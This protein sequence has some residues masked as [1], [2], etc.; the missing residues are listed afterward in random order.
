[1]T[2]AR[3]PF[4]AAS[5][6]AATALLG[7][8]DG[9]F[10]QESDG[11]SGRARVVVAPLSPGAG[12]D[13]D[14]SEDVAE[15]IREGLETFALLTAVD[16]DQIDDMLDR[17]DLDWERMD[18]VQWRQ[19][20][21]Q[22]DGQL[23]V[24]GTARRE[25]GG[26]TVD[27]TFVDAG[28]G[29]EMDVAPFTVPGDGRRSREDAARR[30]L[31]ALEEQVQFLSS[32][33]NCSEYL[34]ADQYEDALRNCDQALEVNPQSAQA[35]DLRG[36]VYME[37][38]EWGEAVDDLERVVEMEPSNQSALEALAYSH[39]QAGN[40][41]RARQLYQEYLEFN[42]DAQDVRL[43]VAYDLASAGAYR[44]AMQ[45]LEQGI[46]RDS[47]SYPL[48][49]YLG[50]VAIR[51]GTAG[52][53]AR[54][55][56]GATIADTSSIERALEAYGK[57]LALKPDSVE[58]GIFRNMV[59]ANLELGRLDAAADAMDRALSQNPE[60]PALWSLRAT[61]YSR[62][63]NLGEA[64][65]S[66]DS[67]LALDP[68]YPDGHFKRG[69][70]RS[71]AGD[72]ERAL[73]D[74]RASI[75]AGTDP[76]RIAQTLFARGYQ[77]RFQRDRYEEAINLFE[78]ALEFAREEGLRNQLH[79]FTGYSYYLIGRAIDNRN[80]AE[81][82]GPARRALR[83]FEQATPHLSD[84]GDYQARNQEQLTQAL[85]VL[86]YRQNQIIRKSCG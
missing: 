30:I 60:D 50:D 23:V 66:M 76:N 65:A 77:D 13:D 39:A 84:A 85:D 27:A 29:E 56:A 33:A 82:C 2:R 59:T 21:T 35:L 37:R 86:I 70:L 7:L 58:T 61:L 6:V 9:L 80:Q 57:L 22:L 14:F 62:R 12:V 68:E 38:E 10:A 55:A 44:E 18:L 45:I 32:L 31:D 41:E 54:M 63:G 42:P 48:W 24:Y 5:L 4:A 74:F 20:A 11:R 67:A 51:R 64:V 43:S 3:T 16:W 52:D 72:L 49:K 83:L 71:R 73:D 15:R 19:L 69:V 75:E 1:M 28:R 25:S 46:R 17:F 47:T 40:R 79:F 53:G 8:P 36:R 78:T 81:E 34:A 26:V